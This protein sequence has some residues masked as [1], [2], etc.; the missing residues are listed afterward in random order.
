MSPPVD[1]AAAQAPDESTTAHPTV[2]GAYTEMGSPFITM[3]ALWWL[4]LS[5]APASAL[6]VSAPVS[7]IL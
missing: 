4:L 3:P 1:V 2:S 6:H 7:G 5:A